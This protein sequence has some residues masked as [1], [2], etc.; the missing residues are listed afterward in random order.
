MTKAELE[1]RA[2]RRAP[3]EAER[4]IAARVVVKAN[5]ARKVPTP[6]WVKA[7]SKHT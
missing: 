4:R 6:A 5:K 3:S 1:R 7:L 2:G